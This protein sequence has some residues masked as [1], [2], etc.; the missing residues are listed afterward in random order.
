MV[1]SDSRELYRISRDSTARKLNHAEETLSK[2]SSFDKAA[3][4]HGLLEMF[5]FDNL[6]QLT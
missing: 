6:G 2:N 3:E 5:C 1:P 4:A